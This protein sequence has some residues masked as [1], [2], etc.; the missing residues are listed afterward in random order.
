MLCSGRCLEEMFRVKTIVCS[1]I[2]RKEVFLWLCR[3]GKPAT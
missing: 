1:K 2:F 3:Y